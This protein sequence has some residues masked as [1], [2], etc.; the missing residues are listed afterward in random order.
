MQIKT[1]YNLDD[2]VYPIELQ[3]EKVFTPCKICDARGH[4]YLSNG[5]KIV[6]PKCYGDKGKTEWLSKKWQ[7]QYEFISQIGN[8][9]IDLYSNKSETHYMIASTGVGSGRLWKE[10]LLFLTKEEAETEC[11]KRN[12]ETI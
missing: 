10:E 3:Y 2:L 5:E 6:C 1:K 11:K 4:I 8:I 12:L 7:V 9:K